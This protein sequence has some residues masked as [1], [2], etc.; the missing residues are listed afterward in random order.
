MIQIAELDRELAVDLSNELFGAV[1]YDEGATKPVGILRRHVRMPPGTADPA[2]E[3]EVV[4]QRRSGRN[5]AL[6]E[7]ERLSSERSVWRSRFMPTWVTP[8]VPS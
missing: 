6:R 7:D 5:A 1:V 3:G 8:F 4:D 2:I